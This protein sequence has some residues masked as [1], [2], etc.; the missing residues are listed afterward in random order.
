[1]SR[2][3][4]TGPDEAPSTHVSPPHRRTRPS[5]VEAIVGWSAGT[6]SLSQP[7]AQCP[8]THAYRIRLGGE[9]W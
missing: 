1:M 8:T 2:L 4:S 6:A 7:V 5:A 9:D 3:Q